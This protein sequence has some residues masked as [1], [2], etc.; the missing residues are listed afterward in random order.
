VSADGESVFTITDAFSP[1]GCSWSDQD[2]IGCVTRDAARLLTVDPN[3]RAPET[4]PIPRDFARLI[5]EPQWLPG[6][7]WLLAT[8]YTPFEVCVVSPESME[9]RRV[10]V[11]GA[12]G[13][14]GG[15]PLAGSNPR[16]VDGG[17]LVYSHP[18]E[19]VV[20]GVRFDPERL[21]TLSE[22]VELFRGVRRESMHGVLQMAISAAGDLVYGEGAGAIRGRLVWAGPD[23]ARDTLL[24]FPPRLYGPFSLSPDGRRVEI[25]ATS[26][27]GE[28]ELWFMDLDRGTERSWVPANPD[29]EVGAYY[30]NWLSD[31]ERVL[32]STAEGDTSRLVIVDARRAT[33]ETEVWTGRGR[34]SVHQVTADGDVLLSVNGPEKSHTA[35]TTLDEV[36]N[37]PRDVDEA[38]PP[39]LDVPGTEVFPRYSPD[40]EWLLYSS[41]HEG[42]FAAYVQKVESGDPPHRV[43]RGE[44]GIGQ[45][46]PSGDA[47]YFRDRQSFYRVE[48]TG[49]PDNPFSEPVFYLEGDFLNV[50]GPELEVHPD[51]RRLLLLEGPGERTTTR[52]NFIQNFARILEERL[53]GG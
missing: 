38:F 17:Y 8:C 2:R 4:R 44:G 37:L 50:P 12:A 32:L 20:L 5:A 41:D 21:E 53:G 9:I 31:S 1:Y 10:M 7:Q 19:N 33:G 26:D 23:G 29:A 51:G 34:L 40:G 45:W 30:G 39:I 24:A 36:A 42:P 49:D 13:S 35:K 47:L 48:V 11:E 28:A 3:G 52:L 15:L 6:G 16:Y 43:S 27:V 14:V 22:P 18:E 46:T 25:K